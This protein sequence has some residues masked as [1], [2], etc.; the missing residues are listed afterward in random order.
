MS[1]LL[2]DLKVNSKDI[3]KDVAQCL[4]ASS[5]QVLAQLPHTSIASNIIACCG[6]LIIPDCFEEARSSLSQTKTIDDDSSYPE[7][8]SSC[9]RYAHDEANETDDPLAAKFRNAGTR[10]RQIPLYRFLREDVFKKLGVHCPNFKHPTYKDVLPT[11]QVGSDKVKSG[12]YLVEKVRELVHIL[13][14]EHD[15]A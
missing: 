15:D 6:Y 8:L 4:F 7:K 9:I 5:V 10:L 13:D 11:F 1:Y 14:T 3:E 2:L 12:L